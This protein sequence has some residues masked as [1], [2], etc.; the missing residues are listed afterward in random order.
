MVRPGGTTEHSIHD[1]E[2]VRVEDVIDRDL[3]HGV[4]VGRESELQAISPLGVLELPELLEAST[5][6]EPAAGD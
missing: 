1:D 3:I 4:G 5:A 2:P 6:N